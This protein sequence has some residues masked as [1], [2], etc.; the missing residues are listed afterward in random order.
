MALAAPPPPATDTIMA[1]SLDDDIAQ[2]RAEIQNLTARRKLLTSSLL[3]STKVQARLFN[4][5]TSANAIRPEDNTA[6]PLNI[7]NVQ[8]H[9]HSNS[10]RLAF[11]ITSF[12]FDDPSPELQSKNPLLGIRFDICNR[13]GKFDAPYYIFCIRPGEAA[14]ADGLRIHRHTIPALVP[15]DQYQKEYLPQGTPSDRGDDEGH[16]GL[17]GSRVVNSSEFQRQNLHGLVGRVRQDLVSW[18]LR[19]DAIEWLKEELGLSRPNHKQKEHGSKSSRDPENTDSEMFDGSDEIEDEDEPTGK[20]NVTSLTLD[21]VSARQIRIIWADDQLARLKI[22]DTGKI[23]KV[24][25]IGIDGRVKDAERILMGEHEKD[26]V[27]VMKLLERLEM[28]YV[29]STEAQESREGN[30][31]SEDT[32]QPGEGAGRSLEWVSA[33]V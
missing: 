31:G 24:A 20:F 1:D 8:E 11:G 6:T 27:S 32:P 19:Q 12:P 18:R 4:K 17:D 5:P 3:S 26:G 13:H 28:L 7:S 10:H 22:S 15:L 9:A 14:G 16:A 21:D 25:V 29:K 30:P 2:V 23:E 33:A